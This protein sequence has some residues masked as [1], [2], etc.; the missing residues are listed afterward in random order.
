MFRKPVRL[1]PLVSILS[2]ALAAMG[3][4]AQP[5][6]PRPEHGLTEQIEHLERQLQELHAQLH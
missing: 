1:G 2:A 5:Q 4:I 3:A 6:P